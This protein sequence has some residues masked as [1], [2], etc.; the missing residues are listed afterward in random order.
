MI[1]Y[2]YSTPYASI[3]NPKIMIILYIL[4]TNTIYSGKHITIFIFAKSF[5]GLNL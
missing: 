3:I 1:A 5:E 4:F 2:T